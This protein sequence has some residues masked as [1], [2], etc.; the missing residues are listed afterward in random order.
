MHTTIHALT[1]AKVAK[2]TGV[3]WRK[4][5][6]GTA[7]LVAD[8]GTVLGV[9]RTQGIFLPVKDRRY[10]LRVPGVAFTRYVEML[11]RETVIDFASYDT[12]AEA[13]KAG[14]ALIQQM[15]DL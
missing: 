8:D 13:Q 9:I 2:K 7:V 3:A 14:L 5:V 10:S 6:N 11:N 12:M 15:K 4:P 1:A